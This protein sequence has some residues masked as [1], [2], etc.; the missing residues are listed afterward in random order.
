[1][2][3]ELTADVARTGQGFDHL[4]RLVLP[5]FGVVEVRVEAGARSSKS[6]RPDAAS[7][8]RAPTGKGD[9][10]FSFAP[11]PQLDATTWAVDASKTDLVSIAYDLYNP[12]GAVARAKL[13]LFRRFSEAAIWSRELKGD[14]LLDGERKLKFGGK[15]TWDGSVDPGDASHDKALFPDGFLTV[16]H[17]PYK[18]R[19][20]LEGKG[21]C[22]AHAAWTYIHV[23][24]EKLELEYGPPES[25]P[26]GAEPA[27]RNH[28]DV[29]K[30]LKDQEKDP[31]TGANKVKVYLESNM[32]KT[33]IS[34]M[35]DNSG[36]TA[37]ENR[38]GDGPQIPIF[39]KIWLRSSAGTAVLAP[40]GIGLERFMW[41]WQDKAVAPTS[42]FAAAAQTFYKDQTKP[43]GLCCHG[44]RGGKRAGAVTA[45][46][47][48]SF[49]QGKPVFPDRAGYDAQDTLKD[50]D[51]PFPVKQLT[52]KRKWV[53]YSTAWRSGKLASKTGV[54][55]NPSRMA[56][57]AYQL[58]VY[59]TRILDKA[60]K[61]RSFDVEDDAP[62][63]AP[64][65]IKAE[66]G[67]FE[68]WRLV[69]FRRLRKKNAATWEVPVAGLPNWYRPAYIEYKMVQ[70]AATNVAAADWNSRVKTQVGTWSATWEQL[71]V[72]PAVDQAA[73][74]TYGLK[75]RTRAEYT[76]AQI[77]RRLKELQPALSA[78]E[79]NYMAGG[80]LVPGIT[81]ALSAS[82]TQ[83][84]NQINAIMTNPTYGM[85]TAANYANKTAGFA[86]R[87]VKAAFEGEFP[88]DDGMCIFQVNQSH[89]LQFDCTTYLFGEAHDFATATDR[90]ASF[91]YYATDAMYT[92]C[93]IPTTN[94]DPIVGH[95]VGH[96]MFL[97]HPLGTAE[98]Q[99]YKAHDIAVNNCLM[100][101]AY[102]IARVFCGFCQL[103]LRGWDKS[104]LDPAS[105]K[106]TKP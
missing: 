11:G 69:H 99:D 38:W 40:K 65:Q 28:R 48:V 80:G 97:P 8:P 13:E 1:M 87:A 95:E 15:D 93:S 29:L 56:G 26:V 37:Y 42:A 68:I 52:E 63:T 43:K 85:D 2:T 76:T 5:A 30:M 74:G 47:P 34:Q 32:F 102:N 58:R 14:E 61:A 64:T 44:E 3:L 66:T 54:C 9:D 33:A 12:V 62:L 25:A 35:F 98:N 53:A 78:V 50:G 20:T 101:Y 89:N 17:S 92:A 82:L 77:A 94:H 18:L 72:D 22:Q 105:A 104:K 60:D 81:P 7:T 16:E 79:C 27:R 71:Y 90:K 57:D 19:I 67:I 88:A 10:T 75:V 55:F 6:H 39:C 46:P 86:Q 24:V 73:V 100:S 31:P 106:N 36:F 45:G 59:A 84:R 83:A 41:D 91:L 4:N 96:H 70:G 51:F 23:L 49:G 21:V 103:R